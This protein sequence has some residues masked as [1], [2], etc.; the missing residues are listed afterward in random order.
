MKI[1]ILGTGAYGLALANMFNQNDNDIV[2][3]TRF[4]EEKKLLEKNRQIKSLPNV[5]LPLDFKYS[6]NMKEAIK[7]RDL[8]VMAVP[9]GAVNDVSMELAK[10]Y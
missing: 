1:A 10:Y 2:L 5:T 9:A 6:C 4:N 7:D 3:W 8:I